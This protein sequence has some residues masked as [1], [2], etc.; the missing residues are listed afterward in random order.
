MALITP[1]KQ[2]LSP[3]RDG[4]QCQGPES[5]GKGGADDGVRELV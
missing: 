2:Q 3:V 5:T 1:D 4:D